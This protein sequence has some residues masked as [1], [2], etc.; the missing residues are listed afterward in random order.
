MP[1]NDSRERPP[2]WTWLICGIL[3][4]A[5]LVNYA[6]R[7]TVTQ[8]SVEIIAA[9][10]TDREGYGKA[11]GKFGYGF[12][13][14]GLV[15]G[16][17]ADWIS[18][19]WLY[20]LVV[21]AWSAAGVASGQ[22]VT[23]EQFGICRFLLG[24]FEAG[25]WPCALRMTQRTFLPYERTRGNGILQSGASAAQVLV[26][27]ALLQLDRWDSS[28]WRLSC[29][30]MGAV[31][32]PWALLWL[33]SVRERDVRRPVI[34]TDEHA[35]GTGRSI[36][37]HELPLWRVFAS[38]RWWLLLLTVVSIN[39]PWH[40]IRVWMPD[41]LRADHKY[42]KEF[43]DDFSAVYYVSTFFG[44]LSAGWIVGWLAGRGWNV[45]SARMM[46]FGAFAV[47][48]ACS[49]P[50]AFQPRGPLLLG[51]LLLIAFGS[52]GVAPIY[53]SLNQEMSG[54][55]QGK[56]GGSLSFLLWLILGLMHGQI[57]ERVKADPEIRPYLFAVVGVL[58]LIAC[59]ALA[60]FWGKRP[61]GEPPPPALEQGT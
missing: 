23:L 3:F 37:I 30:I 19:R 35:A 9:F 50:A 49:V 44:S 43:V 42:A 4:L 21:L 31:G 13:L 61:G 46:T 29:G 16:V 18:I 12:A 60:L 36:E 7:V 24:L 58:P 59:A 53:Y 14:G 10:Q 51:L 41:T 1:D 33:A 11:E 22:S 32:L 8:R 45:H 27:L 34:Q 47:L 56:V 25:H 17:L 48:V 6:N 20:P 39:V 52:L 54:R 55:H 28:G 38:K 57:G 40:Y 2:A 26:P 5:T 15:F